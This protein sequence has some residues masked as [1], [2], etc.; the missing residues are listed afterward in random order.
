MFIINEDLS[1]GITRGDVVCLTV[2][3]EDDGVPYEFQIGETLR[4]KVF[5][6]KHCEKVVLKKDFLITR[7]AT[8]AQIYLDG[9]ETR[10]GELISKPQDYWYEIE[11]NPDTNPQTIVGYDENGP[12]ILR[13]FPEGA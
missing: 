7:A 10:I 5:E 11:L 9:E 2:T 4:I 13:L 3:A 12:K 8:E 1:L 6:R